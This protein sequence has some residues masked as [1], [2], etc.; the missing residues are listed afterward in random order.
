MQP[1]MPNQSTHFFLP[2]SRGR[3]IGDLFEIQ[4][5]R[6][7]VLA[8]MESNPKEGGK[9][10]EKATVLCNYLIQ[11]IANNR[12]RQAGADNETIV[13]FIRAFFNYIQVGYLSAA[14][15]HDELRTY[16]GSLRKKFAEPVHEFIENEEF[17]LLTVVF[18]IYLNHQNPAD[19][20]QLLQVSTI[21]DSF[22]R[23]SYAP[24]PILFQLEGMTCKELLD[25]LILQAAEEDLIPIISLLPK[26][27]AR[28][29]LKARDIQDLSRSIL[30]RIITPPSQTICSQKYEGILRYTIQV[31]KKMEGDETVSQDKRLLTKLKNQMTNIFILDDE[32]LKE[33]QYKPASRNGY[34][35]ASISGLHCYP[36]NGHARFESEERIIEVQ[37]MYPRLCTPDCM[38]VPFMTTVAS[39]DGGGYFSKM[40]T[41]PRREES[42]EMTVKSIEEVLQNPIND[43]KKD[44][45]IAQRRVIGMDSS[46][47][48]RA[49]W[50]HQNE[51]E[52]DTLDPDGLT[53]IGTSYLLPFYEIRDERPHHEKRAFPNLEQI[54]SEEEEAF[55][56][57]VSCSPQR[58]VKRFVEEGISLPSNI[59]DFPSKK[60]EEL[61]KKIK[62]L[63]QKTPKAKIWLV[64]TKP[65]QP[66]LIEL[67]TE[68]A[69]FSSAALLRKKASENGQRKA[70][71][72]RNKC[73]KGH[74]VSKL[75]D[76]N[77]NGVTIFL[78]YSSPEAF[79]NMLI[80]PPVSSDTEIQKERTV[81][82][83]LLQHS[84][85]HQLTTERLAH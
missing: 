84:N 45:C 60:S 1:V 36:E 68:V 30:Q 4:D 71:G 16:N 5:S 18:L 19:A 20:Y 29:W 2:P 66:I 23:A 7:K 39:S 24:F 73:L 59:R 55:P 54:S 62:R 75:F 17:S 51:R 56:I 47:I 11:Q 13:K 85:M 78:Q 74:E 79:M 81:R 12:L 50:I 61:W 77:A 10:K 3:S 28:M 14:D 37:M 15:L 44:G 34:K 38:I 67:L 48:A 26:G 43:L 42:F 46:R 49:V 65:G 8:L 22:R 41:F 27:F 83:P 40:S 9:E 53:R 80:K 70:P 52:K 25:Q 33:P 63:L 64:P 58:S 35:S 32:H 82:K 21:Q 31:V 69:E 72:P 57:D 76:D 6:V